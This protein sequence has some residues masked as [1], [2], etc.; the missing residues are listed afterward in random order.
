MIK[1]STIENSIG[2][3]TTYDE[4]ETTFQESNIDTENTLPN[5]S[6]AALAQSLLA[7]NCYKCSPNKIVLVLNTCAHVVSYKYF[8]ADICEDSA[9]TLSD[10]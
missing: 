4:L 3:V 8:I 6:N 5:I 10:M 7:L 1:E 2:N 9:I